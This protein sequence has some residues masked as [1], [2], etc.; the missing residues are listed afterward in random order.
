[1]STSKNWKSTDNPNGP[2]P[3]RIAN[4]F[5]DIS[6]AGLTPEQI[7][8]IDAIC[9]EDE[10]QRSNLAKS[11]WTSSDLREITEVHELFQGASFFEKQR[12]IVERIKNGGPGPWKTT[13]NPKG[14]SGRRV[15]GTFQDISLAGAKP[16]HIDEIDAECVERGTTRKAFAGHLLGSD[17]GLRR[18]LKLFEGARHYR[19]FKERLSYYPPPEPEEPA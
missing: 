14:P 3:D 15:L 8:A 19:G 16:E 17:E 2:S 5:R 11:I 18:F 7:D 12:E 13:D 6:L 1:V 9:I 10:R 4:T